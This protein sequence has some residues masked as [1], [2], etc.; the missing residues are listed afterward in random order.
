VGYDGLTSVLVI[1][2]NSGSVYRYLG[3]PEHVYQGLMKASSKGTYFNN[4][5]KD[6]YRY[7]KS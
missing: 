4:E 1:E 7:S 2:F 5:I 6:A 3:V